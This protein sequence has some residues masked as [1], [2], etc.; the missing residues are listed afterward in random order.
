MSTNNT[1]MEEFF[2]ALAITNKSPYYASLHQLTKITSPQIQYYTKS[3]PQPTRGWV[4][5]VE[6][7]D[8]RKVVENS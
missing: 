3:K 7:F 1:T 5:W 6:G 8:P 4:M 2:K